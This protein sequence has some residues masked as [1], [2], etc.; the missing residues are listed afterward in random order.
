MFSEGVQ[1]GVSQREASGTAM[2]MAACPRGQAPNFLPSV[3]EKGT[4]PLSV[5]RLGSRVF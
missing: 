5:N 2:A 1:K 4:L 3:A